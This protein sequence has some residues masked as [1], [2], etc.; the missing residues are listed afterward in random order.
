MS[1]SY[2]DPVIK[3]LCSRSGNC[4]AFP[5]CEQRLELKKQNSK[6]ISFI[7]EIAHI[8]GLKPNSPR[9]DPNMT[10]EERNSI[11][12]LILLCPTHHEIIDK[13]PD[14]YTVEKILKMK[15][16]HERWVEESVRKSM[17]DVTYAELKVIIDYLVEIN[18]NIKID[19]DTIPLKDKIKRNSLSSK[20][21][22]LIKH[23]L[24]KVKLV[25]EYIERYPKGI[26]FGDRLKGPIIDEY[27]RLKEKEKLTGDELFYG[28]QAFIERGVTN[29][30]EKA[31]ALA[32]LTY[33]FEKCEVFEK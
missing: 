16:D 24:L 28:L 21:E 1:R 18:E 17:P 13:Q 10:D 15:M 31:A 9:Y 11:D 14:V 19:F 12:N 20:A 2:R 8:R 33:F 23:G 27:L 26:D 5:G 25:E 30:L 22:T 3:A 6:D 7:G 32:V 4:C 29:F